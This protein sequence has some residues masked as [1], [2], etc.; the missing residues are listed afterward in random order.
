MRQ[1]EH[2]GFNSIRK[3]GPILS[4]HKPK[5]IFLVTGKSSYEK[6]GSKSILVELLKEYNITHFDDFETNPKFNDVKKG[7][8]IFK[9]NNCDFIIAIGGGSVM[10]I[11]KLINIFAANTGE[12]IRYIKKERNIENKG[13]ILVA[14]PTT[15]G[16]GSEATHF[17]VVY[18][19]KTK[20]SLAHEFVLP[21]YA[22]IDQQLTMSL[23]Q[24]I[25]ASTGMDALG[26]AIESY[27][28]INS[29]DESK[30]YARQAIKIIMKNLASSVNNPTEETREAMAIAAHLT[31]KAINI[32][33]TTA[34]HAI[35]YPITSYFNVPHG[36]AVALTLAKML[37]YNSQVTE[38]DV[39]DKRGVAYVKETVNE[40]AKLMGAET[41]EEASK[42]IINLMKEIGLKVKLGELGIKTDE[43]VELII[44]NGFNP[45]RVKNNPK[46]LTEDN[47]RKILKEIR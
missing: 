43:D 2:S 41:I 47:L 28:C 19:N 24:H 8:E 37:V 34:S 42:K 15:S 38:E 45:D 22:I 5:S 21:D 9:E 17:A 33:K 14:I 7:L 39:L 32:S 40:I 13:K 1:Q 10:D 12:Q 46:K 6:S 27:W 31:G 3:L 16:S 44:K 18:V 30:E 26:Q 4:K 25:T 36:H 20:Y 29:T 23:P 11:A 35:S